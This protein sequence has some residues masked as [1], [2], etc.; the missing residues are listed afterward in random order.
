MTCLDEDV[1]VGV[2]RLRLR[3]VSAVSFNLSDPALGANGSV[4]VNFLF[5]NEGPLREGGGMA[6]RLCGM[7]K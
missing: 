3:D 6:W 7:H 2:L 5:G 1:A 4:R